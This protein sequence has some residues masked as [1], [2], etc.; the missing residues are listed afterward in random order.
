[1]LKIL[2]V[3]TSLRFVLLVPEPSRLDSLDRVAVL[4]KLAAA[5]APAASLTTPNVRPE[6][7]MGRT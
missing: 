2:L 5:W 6:Y 4:S 1:L 3:T 7:Q